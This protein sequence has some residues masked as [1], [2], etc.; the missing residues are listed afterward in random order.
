MSRIKKYTRSFRLSLLFAFL[1]FV[2]MFVTMAL[3]SLGMF[4]MI[5]FEFVDDEKVQR[6]PFFMF[7]IVSIIVGTTIAMIVSRRP[8][9]PLTEVMEAVDKIAEGDYCVRVKP[10][11]AEQFYQLGEK[12]NRRAEELDNVEIM[13]S[14][15]V[16]SFSHEFKTPIAS[17]RGFAKALKWNDL[18]DEEKNEYLDII[19]DE[20]ER[21]SDLSANILYLSKIE[22][23]TILTG[24]S[25]FN[26]CEQIRLVIALMDQKIEVKRLY[27]EMAGQETLVKG[28]E[29]MLRQVWINLLDNAI[30]FSP[31]GE[32][33]KVH[34]RESK[35]YVQVMISD[36]GKGMTDDI[37]KHIFDKFYQGD[38]SHSTSGNGLGLSIVKKIIDLH[39]GTIQVVSSSCGCTFEVILRKI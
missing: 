23:Q 2:V 15:F 24:K 22:K 33:I 9:A 3:L 39:D 16:G 28:N 21:L 12:F 8:L 34:V 25:F 32:K 13:R 37:K 17:I 31:E 26:V 7:A 35:K 4:I 30:K 19:I 6:L 20:T 38:C 27:V 14:D 10:R 36:Q 18:T 11:G 5:H 1:V 29:E